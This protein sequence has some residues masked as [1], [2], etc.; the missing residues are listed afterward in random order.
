MSNPNALSV[1]NKLCFGLV[2]FIYL[3]IKAKGH[4]GHLYCSKICT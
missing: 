2:I 1:S 4:T 3:I